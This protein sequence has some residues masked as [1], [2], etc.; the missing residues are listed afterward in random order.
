MINV[1]VPWLLGAAAAGAV[2]TGVLHFLSVRRPRV[3]LLPTMRFLPDRSVRAVSRSARPSDLWLL[4]LRAGALLL[5]GVALAGVTWT[6]GVL[7]HGRVVVVDRNID[8]TDLSAM[9]VRVT[10]LLRARLD[11]DTVTRFVIVDSAAHVLS[12][13]AMRTL[14]GDTLKASAGQ[15]A[16]STLL[17]AGVRGAGSLVR[18]EG[19]IDSVDLVLVAPFNSA[20]IDAGVPAARALWPGNVRLVDLASAET[21]PNSSVSTVQLVGGGANA[22]VRTAFGARLQNAE[23]PLRSANTGSGGSANAASISIEWP[24]SGIPAAWTA[25]KPDTIGAVIARGMALVWPFERHAHASDSLLKQGRAIAWWSDGQV[26]ALE[27]KTATGCVRQVGVTVTTSSDV[28]QGHGARPLLSALT[29]PCGRHTASSPLADEVQKALEGADRA[30]PA[31]AFRVAS[32]AQT[33]FG[34]VMLLLSLLLLAVEWWMRDRDS[35]ALQM[36][37]APEDQ[38]R[39][40]A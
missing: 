12:V 23:E 3:L 18:E 15:T 8:S 10:A 39:N 28:L 24:S 33:P 36:T 14:R 21:S 5:A 27:L 1:G 16:L 38:L 31:S 34:S 19:N 25:V 37:G 29:A 20:M 13:A 40:V 6:G 17:L 2:L 26:A 9:R 30:A 4:L 22:A 7:T 32:A 11:G 35:S